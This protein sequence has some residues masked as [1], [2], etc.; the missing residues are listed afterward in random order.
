MADDVR[1]LPR[2]LQR[3][4]AAQIAA[5]NASNRLHRQLLDKLT[6]FCTDKARPNWLRV[7][8]TGFTLHHYR[9]WPN[10]VWPTT[11]GSGGTSSD[12]SVTVAGNLS[13]AWVA[14]SAAQR[15]RSEQNQQQTSCL[16]HTSEISAGQTWRQIGLIGF[17]YS[18]SVDDFGE[19][20][21]NATSRGPPDVNDANLGTWRIAAFDNN[22]YTQFLW[23]RYFVSALPNL[24]LA[25]PLLRALGWRRPGG[26]GA[27][28]KI[29][30]LHHGLFERG[31]T[32][33]LGS[34]VFTG[35][36]ACKPSRIKM[37]PGHKLSERSPVLQNFVLA[38]PMAAER[39]H[40]PSIVSDSYP[41]HAY[42]PFIPEQQ[43]APRPPAAVSSRRRNRLAEPPLVVFLT[44]MHE[45][46]RVLLHEERI[47]R[48][49]GHLLTSR[50][51]RF[52]VVG[53]PARPRE[54]AAFYANVR[55]V[56]GV[57]GGAFANL[58]A[59]PPG[60]RIVEV[61]GYSPSGGGS[62]GIRLG[63]A[64][65]SRGIGH[66]HSLYF[67]RRWPKHYMMKSSNGTA[68]D[69]SKVVVDEQDF[70][71]HVGSVFGAWRDSDW[72]PVPVHVL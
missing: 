26:G 27:R 41:A 37:L 20:R 12:V 21:C 49:V 62:S 45:R 28:R 53:T 72:G 52:A 6:D 11:C 34:R 1:S 9:F 5:Q 22:P 24:G 71:R 23:Q 54:P 2:W 3:K 51:Y 13:A 43:P 55:G 61:I 15:C 68:D 67:P 17:C 30:L 25:L 33:N 64:S 31:P 47:V 69:G 29:E 58:H 63:Y 18:A 7:S 59:C 14:P 42:W 4:R 66:R 57:H 65:T 38:M 36:A 32:R 16:V 39:R 48:R 44:R 40:P 56:I 19:L 60:A 8:G 35:D 50:D 70:L 46:S 10:Y